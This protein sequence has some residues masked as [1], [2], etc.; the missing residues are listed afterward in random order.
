MINFYSQQF[1][2]QWQDLVGIHF[3]AT[4]F[5]KIIFMGIRIGKTINACSKYIIMLSWTF[6]LYIVHICI[7]YISDVLLFC[8][9]VKEAFNKLCIYGH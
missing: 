5:I 1:N 8:V 9:R 2:L 3:S 7:L 4:I 6:H